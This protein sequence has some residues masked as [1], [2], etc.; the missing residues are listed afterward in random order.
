M[1]PLLHTTSTPI[2]GVQIIQRSPFEDAR[3]KFSRM[4]C[5]KELLEL[6]WS[7]PVAQINLSHTVAKGAV[8]GMHYQIGEAAEVKLVSCIAGRVWDVALDLRR[9]SSTY[10]RWHAVE[11][12]ADNHQALLIPKGVAHGF[13]VLQTDST[14]LY[15]H[16]HEYTPHLEAGIRADDPALAITWP[17]EL[18]DWSDRDKALTPIDSS[19]QSSFA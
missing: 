2:Q 11:L 1:K 19:F 18:T 12:S 15:V 6:G 7:D 14:L 9:S 5:T 16:S 13:Q 17:L 10:L 8:R 3:G 4:F